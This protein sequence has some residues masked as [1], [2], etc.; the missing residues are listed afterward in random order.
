MGLVGDGRV[1]LGWHLGVVLLVFLVSGII[2]SSCD[3][4]TAWRSHCQPHSAWR[5][6]QSCEGRAI[7]CMLWLC[8]FDRVA[9][10]HKGAR[11][12][13]SRTFKRV[14]CRFWW[15]DTQDAL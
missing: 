11:T 9:A 14:P 4:C 7:A 10:S 1:L 13:L 15:D 6:V 12:G 8:A 2:I 5:E 3:L